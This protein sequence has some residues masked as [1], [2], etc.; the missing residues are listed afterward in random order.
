MQLASL[1]TTPCPAVRLRR[2][3]PVGVSAFM[4]PA[5]L[6]RAQI[7]WDLDNIN[8]RST[9]HALVIGHRLK[10]S[11]R[12]LTGLTPSLS[13]FANEHTVQRLQERSSDE[14]WA[15]VLELLEADIVVAGLE[16]DAA[17]LLM[18]RHMIDFAAAH[19]P[20]AAVICVSNDQGFAPALERC[21]HMGAFTVAVGT[22]L[23][24]A[25]FNWSQRP[26][27]LPVACAANCIVAWHPGRP[28]EH[29]K[30]EL[31]L[32]ADYQ[33]RIGAAEASA[34]A[35]KLA[36]ASAGQLKKSYKGVV[37][38]RWL[39][40][41]RP[42]QHPYQLDGEEQQQPRL[43]P[44]QEEEDKQEE[45]RQIELPAA[46]ELLLPAA[47]LALPAGAADPCRSA[48]SSSSSESAGGGSATAVL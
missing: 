44:Q 28:Q 40:P 23:R 19:G 20:S 33:Q 27:K 15:A 5:D 4:T 17:D 34:S 16:K 7:F 10:S 3:Q 21:G 14:S 32:V 18:R 24:T 8:A 45:E 2:R 39:N 38:T 36:G 13:A 12:R 1:S 6:R 35:S 43:P 9:E 31:K 48:S 29:S 22:Y 47:E 46:G 25:G 30:K 26:G 11:V 41:D 42:W 37:S